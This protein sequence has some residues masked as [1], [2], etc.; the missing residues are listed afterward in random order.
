[1][2]GPLNRVRFVPKRT[3]RVA[4]LGAKAEVVG[5]C[6]AGALLTLSGC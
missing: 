6:R 1:M 2:D 3:Y 5:A 4:G